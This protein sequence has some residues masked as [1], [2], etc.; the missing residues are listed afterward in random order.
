QPLPSPVADLAQ[1]VAMDR[2]QAMRRRQDRGRLD[3]AAEG[4]AVDR[5]N[6]LGREPLRKTLHLRPAVLREIDAYITGKAV[7]RR[8]GRRPVANQKQAGRYCGVF[9]P[10]TSATRRSACGGPQV[11]GSY[12]NIGLGPW[13]TGSTIAQAA[14]TTS[15]LAKSVAS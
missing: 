14:S 1:A 13:I 12:S 4:A 7:L 15:C 8:Q 11:P 3:G 2:C 5:G 10:P 9:H 6:R